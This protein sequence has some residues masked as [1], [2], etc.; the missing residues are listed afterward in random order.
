[1]LGSQ[2]A[3]KPCLLPLSFPQTIS[4]SDDLCPP[5]LQH[6][7]QDR[8]PL[9]AQSAFVQCT[10][11]HCPPGISALLCSVWEAPCTPATQ[12]GVLRNPEL[13]PWRGRIWAWRHHSCPQPGNSLSSG[14]EAGRCRRSSLHHLCGHSCCSH[15][16]GSLLHWGG[17]T[18]I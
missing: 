7:G 8:H 2:P 4:P 13:L 16:P 3:Q 6:R 18:E 9:G 1:M 14:R 17:S 12:C 5:S 10:D 15:Q 11:P